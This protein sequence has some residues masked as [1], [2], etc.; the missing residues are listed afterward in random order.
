[1]GHR[2]TNALEA[3]SSLTNAIVGQQDARDAVADARKALMRQA[4]D[5]GH[6]LADIASAAGISRQR[7]HELTSEEQ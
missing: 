4:R 1:V 3:I 7:V 6:T 2:V 5:E